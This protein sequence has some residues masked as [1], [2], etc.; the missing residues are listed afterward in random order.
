MHRTVSIVAATAAAIAA[1]AIS[2]SARSS[3]GTLP[4]AT[5][6]GVLGLTGSWASHPVV[7]PGEVFFR[8]TAS[9]VQTNSA[10]VT[11]SQ[12]SDGTGQVF[13]DAVLKIVVK[14]ADGTRSTFRHDFSGSCAVPTGP[15]GPV[16]LTALFR[17]GRN[18]VVLTLQDGCGGDEAA[19][20]LY[21]TW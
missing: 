20:P 1:I 3:G 11:L 17:P 9:N 18:T 15:I 10:P 2:A 14:H 21:L 13:V 5:T 8:S 4:S 19:T 7:S 12:L 6:G 16:D